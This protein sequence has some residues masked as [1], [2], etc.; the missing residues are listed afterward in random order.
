[1]AMPTAGSTGTATA[2]RTS[3]TLGV[4]RTT[5]TAGTMLTSDS[6]YKQ[7]APRSA[8]G[9][10]AY[11]LTVKTTRMEENATPAPRQATSTSKKPPAFQGSQETP[12]IVRKTSN[13]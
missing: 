3:A 8:L 9:A 6:T 5:T 4:P 2:T 1:M 7:Q 13:V 11:A 10:T 12:A